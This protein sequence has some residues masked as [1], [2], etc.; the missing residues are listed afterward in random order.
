MLNSSVNYVFT[1]PI[2]GT[3]VTV[4]L[5]YCILNGPS[6]LEGAGNDAQKLNGQSYFYKTCKRVEKMLAGNSPDNRKR[7]HFTFHL[8]TGC[9]VA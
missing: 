6:Q 5:N 2:F 9:D 3:A 7:V 1:K 4:P 8:N